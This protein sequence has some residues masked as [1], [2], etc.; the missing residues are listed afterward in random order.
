M[1]DKT[2]SMTGD[3]AELDLAFAAQTV[4]DKPDAHFA[5]F[6]S[7][8]STDLFGH[9]VLKGAFD[10]SIKAKGLIGPRGVKLLAHHDWHKPA[11]I[12]KRLQTVG[13][14]LEIE[15]QLNLGVSYVRDL[16]EAAK[17]NDGLNYS[18]GFSVEEFEF[19]DDEQEK[20]GVELD[21][22]LVIKQGDLME[23]SVVVFPAQLEAEMT[24]I[25]NTPPNT[26]AEFEKALI[27]EGL[28]RSRSEAKRL[29][30][31]VKASAH[32]FQGKQPPAAE[33]VDAT[34]RPWLDAHVLKAATDLTAK[35]KAILGSR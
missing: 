21:Y 22:W 9:R 32:L 31:A 6:A 35:A 20:G 30:Q 14:N 18:V 16:Y 15:A 19:V 34:P 7:T 29:T 3:R 11:G 23:V 1:F 24:I 8:P 2:Q 33:L 17:F 4:T 13:D 10:K 12:I 27:A 28:C 25:K 26:L 5:G